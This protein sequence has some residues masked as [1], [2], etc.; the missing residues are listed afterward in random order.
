MR[1]TSESVK[2]TVIKALPSFFKLAHKLISKAKKGTNMITHKLSDISPGEET[3]IIYIEDSD[4]KERFTDLGLIP[5]T[6]V[7]CV[8]R[9]PGKDMKA[10][11]VRGAVIALRNNDCISIRV[12]KG[13]RRLWD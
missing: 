12:L 10:Y 9:S 6:R 5:G 8:G 11:L 4:L 13:E 1:N 3:E 7:K 2:Y